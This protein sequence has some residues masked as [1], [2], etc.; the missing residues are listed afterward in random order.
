MFYTK[1]IL[2]L[3]LVGLIFISSTG[4]GWSVST[5]QCLMQVLN[6]CSQSTNKCCH[7][8][9]TDKD[10][11][12]EHHSKCC[13]T[14]E[15]IT[16]DIDFIESN[17]DTENWSTCPLL[18]GLFVQDMTIRQNNNNQSPSYQLVFLADKAKL[19]KSY[20]LKLSFLQRFLC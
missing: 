1:K 14:F 3:F 4:F 18:S 17:L 9:T 20:K 6:C 11:H 12:S 2:Q 19:S 7:K 5:C 8:D 13:Y 15:Y 16:S 10:D